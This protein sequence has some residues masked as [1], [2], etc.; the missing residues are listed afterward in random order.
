MQLRLRPEALPEAA[1]HECSS[2]GRCRY[3]LRDGSDMQLHHGATLALIVL[4]YLLNGA[5]VGAF[6]MALFNISN[7]L[8]HASKLANEQVNW[9]SPFTLSNKVDE[10]AS[11]VYT[12]HMRRWYM[13]MQLLMYSSLKKSACHAAG[14]APS[15][16]VYLCPVC[17]CIFWNPHRPVPPQRAA[18]EPGA[19][20]A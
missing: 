19:E 5:H 18:P 4:S 6:V 9:R 16:S 8:L 7:P 1:A 11:C 17:G 15:T 12:Q 2:Q 20:R 14:L 3:G 13:R 10:S